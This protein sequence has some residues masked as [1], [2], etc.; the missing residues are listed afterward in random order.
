LAVLVSRFSASASEIVAG[1]LQNYGRAIIIGD[2]STHGKGTVQTIVEMKSISRLLAKLPDKTGAARLTIQKFYLPNGAS[3][4]Q[5]GVVPDIVLP[6]ADA[7][8]QIGES[9]LPNSLIWDEIPSTVFSGHPLDQK[10]LAPLRASSQSRL[11]HLEEFAYL[12]K[13]IAWF[14]DK[15]D[16]K[17]ISLNLEERRHEK[18]ID[19][20]FKKAMRAEKDTLAK[21]DFPYT[22][23]TLG[24][25]LPKPVKAEK[26]ADDESTDDDEVSPDEDP[27]VT[28]VDIPLRESLRVLSDTLTL[29][30]NPQFWADGNA[31]LTVQI[32]KNG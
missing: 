4:Q 21:T 2:Q 1:A 12:K 29:S 16:H 32:S 11:D 30:E 6:S 9:N 22:E 28:K 31:P 15:Q 3:T 18:E 8:M 23:F 26:K 25:P 10:L 27:G 13:N 24:P 7:Y 19:D 17:D 20:A 5:K 14:K